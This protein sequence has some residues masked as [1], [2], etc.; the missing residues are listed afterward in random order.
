[1][2]QLEQ[3]LDATQ[4]KADHPVSVLAIDYLSLLNTRDLGNNLYGQISCAA[5]EMKNLAKRRD[6]AIICLCQV[7]RASGEDGST[8]LNIYSARE[9]GAIEESA[10]FLLGLYRPH[11]HEE[12]DNIIAVQI[13][14]NRKGQDGVEFH[15]TFDRKSLRVQQSKLEL[16]K[17]EF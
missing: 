8:P 13:L 1:M 15:F 9:S 6:L 16:I 7:S 11:L 12:E 14:K 10:D 4:A 5:R 2:E 3:A 17:H